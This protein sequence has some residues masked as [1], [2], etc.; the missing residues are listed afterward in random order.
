MGQVARTGLLVAPWSND[1]RFSQV[2]YWDVA[3]VAAIALTEDRY[4]YGTFEL[5]ADG[6]LN[7]YDVAALMGDVLG[8]RVEARRSDPAAREVPFLREMFTWY[9]PYGP[10]GNHLTLRAILG[11][12]PRTLRASARASSYR[13]ESS[14]GSLSVHLTI[15]P[16]CRLCE[17]CSCAA[18]ASR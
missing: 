1:T 4:L 9:D 12:E 14:V 7:R 11:R 13:N 6:W 8:R 18:L 15:Q 10:L 3:E 16:T 2:D 5:S 17:Y